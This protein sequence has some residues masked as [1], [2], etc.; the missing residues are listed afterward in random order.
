MEVFK[1]LVLGSR[2]DGNRTDLV[3]SGLCRK[4]SHRRWVISYTETAFYQPRDTTG[5][6]KI[7]K[8]IAQLVSAV[9]LFVKALL[10]DL[11]WVTPMNHRKA[12]LI[13]LLRRVS[14][15]PV[16]IDLYISAYSIV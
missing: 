2:E 4:D 10:C 8:F 16:V 12:R 15:K 13:A 1:I 14:R 5:A 11:I 7:S 6:W 9:E 3:L